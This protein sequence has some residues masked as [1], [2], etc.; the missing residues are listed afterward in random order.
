MALQFFVVILGALSFWVVNTWF[1]VHDVWAL[2]IVSSVLWVVSAVVIGVLLSPLD[3][4]LL[5]LK[6]LAAGEGVHL[7]APRGRDGQRMV[8]AL[9]TLRDRLDKLAAATTPAREPVQPPTSSVSAELAD[10]LN[11]LSEGIMI[12]DLALEPAITNTALRLMSSAE[13]NESYRRVFQARCFVPDQLAVIEEQMAKKPDRPRT[14]IVQL[15][16]PRQFIRRYSAPL[17]NDEHV[18][19]GFLVSFQ[20]ITHEVEQ[21]RLRQDF[22][23]NA[24]HELRTP[25]TSVKLLLENLVGG[26]KDDPAVADDFLNDA[27]DEIDRMHELVNDLLDMAALEGGRQNLTFTTFDVAKVCA[28]ATT[29]I[30]PQAKQR[31]VA[32]ITDLPPGELLLEADRNRLRQVLVN[33]IANAVKFTPAG[34]SVTLKGWVEAGAMRFTIA[35]TGIGIPAQ[36]LPHIFDRF[37]RVTRARSR[38]Q[39]GSGLGLTIVKNA[40]DAHRG[41]INVESTENVGTTVF[42]KLPLAQ[43]EADA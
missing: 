42:I 25:V 16:H 22:I 5:A 40:I 15:E 7:P 35:D 2:I 1:S 14:D 37:F 30:V 38:M 24:S 11:G 28:E 8:E 43:A 27:L 12:Q 32:L 19:T 17:Y 29:T 21:D 33:L 10:V 36:D 26:A 23:S 4:I 9:T 39:G 20:D 3:H 41:E 18:Q 13:Q 31:D 6:H 34:G